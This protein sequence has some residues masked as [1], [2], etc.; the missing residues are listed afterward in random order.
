MDKIYELQLKNGVVNGVASPNQPLKGKK[1]SIMSNPNYFDELLAKNSPGSGLKTSK[2]TPTNGKVDESGKKH[3][4]RNS[5]SSQ[6]SG[7][8]KS[9]T[10]KRKDSSSKAKNSS[11]KSKTKSRNRRSVSNPL[12]MYGVKNKRLEKNS[13]KAKK[14]FEG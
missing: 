6:K 5:R 8:G 9:K 14:Q 12:G 11:T 7:T 1:P 10:K 2:K 3:R 4:R 13:R